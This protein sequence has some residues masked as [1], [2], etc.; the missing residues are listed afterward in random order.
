[1]DGDGEHDPK[2]IP[3]LVSPIL[4]READVVFGIREAIARPSER[5]INW[6]VR[7]RMRVADTGTGFRAFRKAIARQLAIPGR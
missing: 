3:K 2:D 6:L 5:L 4:K 7:W 1:M